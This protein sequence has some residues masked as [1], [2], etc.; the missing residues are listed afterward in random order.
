MLRAGTARAPKTKRPEKLPS[1]AFTFLGQIFLR[2]AE[3][4]AAVEA[5]VTRAVAHG[6]VAAA[7]TRG[8]I[9]LEVR[10]GI[11]Q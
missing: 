1:P 5:L 10:N 7:G 3:A 8:R 4:F 6:D 2:A 11:A 9:E